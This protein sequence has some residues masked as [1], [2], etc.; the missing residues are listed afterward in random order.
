[1]PQKSLVSVVIPTYSRPDYLVRAINSVLQ[2]TYSPIE[3]IVVDDNG[4]GTP[5]QKETEQSLEPFIAKKQITY[6]RHEHNSNGS[7]ARNTGIKAAHGD[8]ITFLD[9]DDVLH[10]E[11]IEKQVAILECESEYDVAYTGFR[12]IRENNVLKTVVPEKKGNLQYELL[13]CQW[14]I[15]TGSNPLFRKNVF[16]TIGL[17]DASFCR[18]QDIEFMVRVFRKFKIAPVKEILIDRY[19]DSRINNVNY[20]KYLSVKNQFLTTFKDDIECFPKGKQKVIYRNQYADV[21]CHAM[22]AKAFSAA[23]RYYA[24]ANSYKILSLR[25]IAKAVLY[26]FMGR[27][28]E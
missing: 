8:Y 25:I 10:P 18:H 26:G 23:W 7:A 27:K 15:G 5:F 9:D 6:L 14:G 2:Q 13:S 20:E 21:A 1:M 12:I 24:K 11:K 16:E 4:V 17:W 22:Q 28:V 19:I 3:I